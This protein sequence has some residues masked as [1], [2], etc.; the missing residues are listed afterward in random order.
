MPDD[1]SRS[2]EPV[3]SGSTGHRGAVV[4]PIAVI[5]LFLLL[6]FTYLSRRESGDVVFKRGSAEQ[7]AAILEIAKVLLGTQQDLVNLATAGFAAAAFLVTW[8][9]EKRAA[10]GERAWWYL[11]AG[12]MSF[13]A[14]LLFALF[15]REV[16]ISQLGHNAVD[17]GT[18][19]LTFG[20]WITYLAFV[21]G[22]TLI[23]VFALKVAIS[24]DQAPTRGDDKQ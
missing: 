4:A 3:P 7:P 10:I 13:L 18:P 2:T 14:A 21:G 6:A 8:Q 23:G 5:I 1:P 17:L 19:A 12:L 9:R 24:S 20:R 11:A 16:L 15:G 22:G